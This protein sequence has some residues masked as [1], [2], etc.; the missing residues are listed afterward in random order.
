MTKTSL[1]LNKKL[2]EKIE[3]VNIIYMAHRQASKELRS[4]LHVHVRVS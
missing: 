1:G 4:S 3:N 2:S